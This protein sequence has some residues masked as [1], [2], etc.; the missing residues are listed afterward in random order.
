MRLS[1]Q[2]ALGAPAHGFTPARS[3]ARRRRR[4]ALLNV[5]TSFALI[6][7][8]TTGVLIWARRTFRRRKRRQAVAPAT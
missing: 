5:I 6:G 1:G 8:L 4:T 7:L 2:R 3:T